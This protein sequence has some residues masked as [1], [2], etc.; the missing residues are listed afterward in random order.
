MTDLS[1]LK[2]QFHKI[3]EANPFVNLLQ[4]KIVDV[5]AGKAILSMPIQA[6]YTNFYNSAHGGA[7]A[8]LADTSMGMACITTGKKVVTLDMNLNY[9]R[10]VPCQEV[11][12]AVGTL[13]HNGSRTMVAETEIFNNL[14]QLVVAARAT[15][16]VTGKISFE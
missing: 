10:D 9:I 11:L 16:F 1:L 5:S 8:S 15:F 14:Q 6:Q 12:T 13:I 3:Y 2:T 7:L 4:M